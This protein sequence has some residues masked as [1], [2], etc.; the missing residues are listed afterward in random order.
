VIVLIA[1]CA[2]GRVGAHR[3]SPMF[4][5]HDVPPIAYLDA[6]KSPRFDC[7]GLIERSGALAGTCVLVGPSCALTDAHVV[8]GLR[9]D[10]LSAK[11][12]GEVLSVTEIK[13]HPDYEASRYKSAKEPISRKGIDLA[14]IYF[15]SKTAMP[16]AKIWERTVPL[17]SHVFLCGF[18]GAG[19]GTSLDAKTDAQKRC[20]TN[21]IDAIG[22]DFDGKIPDWYYVSDFDGTGFEAKNKC[23]STL[24][25]ELE[26]L[27]TG[28]DSGGGEFIE[29]QGNWYLVG[30]FSTARYFDIDSK[31]ASSYGDLF[32][33][34]RLDLQREWIAANVR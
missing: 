9:A 32:M 27:G 13:V 5:R 20:G 3:I 33:C 6:A 31:D 14:L 30:L 23:G 4:M 16:I 28:G 18:G 21:I 8:A 26:C 22:G 29:D 25:T 19:N 34:T 24:P 2:V 7:I 12:N 15:K 17:G 1:L 10:E 11:L